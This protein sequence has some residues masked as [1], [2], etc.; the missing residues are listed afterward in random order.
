MLLGGLIRGV[1]EPRPKVVCAMSGSAHYSGLEQ[2]VRLVQS[3]CARL[4]VERALRSVAYARGGVPRA[5]SIPLRLV[6]RSTPLHDQVSSS[7]WL[8]R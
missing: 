6:C 1:T 3:L 2:P 5:Y 7:S 4:P 8:G